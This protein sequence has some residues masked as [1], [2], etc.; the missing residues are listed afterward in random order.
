MDTAYAPIELKGRQYQPQDLPVIYF[1]RLQPLAYVIN[2]KAACTLALNFLF[3]CNHG[4]PYFDPNR[5]HDSNFGFVRLGP[6][7][8][9]DRVNAFNQ[10]KPETFSIVR[11]PLQRF[12]SAFISK[13][14]FTG[15]ENY[16]QFRDLVTSL[17]GVDLS[18]DADLAQSCLAF[19]RLIAAQQDV[20]QVDRHFRPQYVNLGLDGPFRIDTILHLEDRDGLRAYFSK[21]AGA[22]KADRFLTQKFNEMPGYVK[23]DLLSDELVDVVRKVYARDYELL[24]YAS[25]RESVHRP[26]RASSG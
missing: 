26:R 9:A 6:D 5:V 25:S 20:G 7:F 12:L 16:H 11:D 3:F 15:D 18:A 2:A 23:D 17:H 13:L 10:L 4:Y 24:G 19:A 21:W 8:A 1:G 22:E 14:V